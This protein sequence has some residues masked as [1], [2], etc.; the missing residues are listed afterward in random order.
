MND[1]IS[2]LNT[3][4]LFDSIDSKNIPEVLKKLNAFVKEYQKN[5]Y[6]MHVGDPAH[7]IGIILQGTIHIIQDDFYGNRNITAS[8]SEGTLFAEAFACAGAAFL[9]VDILASSDAKIMFIDSRKIFISCGKSCAY[10]S[11]LTSN[12]LRIVA[13]KNII[14]SRKIQ[15]IS[16]K[17]TKDKLL[18]YLYSQAK[19]QNSASFDIP[20]NRQG[21]ADYLGVER[22]AL[23]TVIHDLVKQGIIETKRS[24][25]TIINFHPNV[26]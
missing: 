12:L 22:S 2:I 6:I 4:P 17:T 23:S 21:L 11:L 26:S 16:Q 9:P 7:Y 1:Y 15:C 5:E 18:S 3:I 24:N 14:L 20:F 8:F 19:L 10:H 25:F 13:N